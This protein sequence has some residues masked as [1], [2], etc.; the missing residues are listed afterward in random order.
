VDQLGATHMYTIYISG[1][2]GSLILEEDLTI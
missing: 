1:K 2:D